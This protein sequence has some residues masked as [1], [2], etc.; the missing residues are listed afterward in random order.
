[1]NIDNVDLAELCIC[2]IRYALGRQTY[3]G[4][5]LPIL[6][7][8]FLAAIFIGLFGFYSQQFIT[9]EYGSP[10]TSLKQPK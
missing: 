10:L 4:Y 6:T 5:T 9:K 1:M 2:S 8:I 7:A 3:V